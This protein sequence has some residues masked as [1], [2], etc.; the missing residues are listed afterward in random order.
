MKIAITSNVGNGSIVDD[1]IFAYSY[2]E[3]VTSLEPSNI[4]GAT[5]QVSVSA[6][7]VD[8]TPGDIHADSSLL[9]NNTM[10]FIDSDRGEVTFQVKNVSKNAGAVTITGDTLQSRLNVEKTA[11]PHGGTGKNLYTA[12]EYY[13]GL[14]SID[15]TYSTGFAAELQAVPVNFIGWKANVWEQLKLLCAGFSASTTN[16]VGI[17]MIIQNDTLHFRKALTSVVNF[18][19]VEADTSLSVE[20]FDSAKSIVVTNYNTSYG[21]DKVIYDEASSKTDETSSFENQASINDTMQVDAGATLRKRFKVNATLESVN[22]P[23][24]VTQITRTWPFPYTGT[25]GEYVIVGTDD[26][27]IEP[28]QWIGLGGSLKIE[29]V[30]ENGDKLPPGEIEVVVT[31]P[32]VPQLPTA[33]NPAEATYAP[34]KVGVESSGEAEYAALWITGTGVFFDKQEITL[35]TG[36]SDEYSSKD[37]ATSVDNPFMINAF[38]ATSR[39][40][41][42]AQ[43]ACGPKVSVNQSVVTSEF[44][45]TV[46]SIETIGFNKY[47]ID[48]VSFTEGSISI[49]AS[50]KATIAD[51]N[52]IWTDLTFQDFED[53]ALDPVNFPTT[54]LKFNE[55]SVIPL[56]GAI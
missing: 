1:S 13:C 47:R 26:L 23:V 53:T 56:M 33:A 55:F 30:D 35:L 31:A 51:F 43:A 49:Q 28:A 41:A 46:G 6:I 10:S 18:S 50:A 7:G 9:I 3:E 5:S 21:T 48:S 25:T 16:N 37:S 22:Q 45:S 29:L 4:N 20:S 17:E 40:V 36:A 54:A 2:S 34:Y 24:C 19:E 38:N 8:G 44:G 42:A 12:I 52:N 15:P 39:G 32:G 27:P 11:E 14:V